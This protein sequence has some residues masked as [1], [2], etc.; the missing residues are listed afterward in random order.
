MDAIDDAVKKLDG[1]AVNIDGACVTVEDMKFLQTLLNTR[2][3]RLAD[4][5]HNSIDN[6]NRLIEDLS[7]V[8]AKRREQGK[9]I[10][11]EFSDFDDFP[12]SALSD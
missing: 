8:L 2:K 12:E 6:V 1:A 5:L 3:N 9:K 4:R 10:C 11:L 7:G